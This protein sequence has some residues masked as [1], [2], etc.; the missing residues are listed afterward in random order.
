MNDVQFQFEYYRYDDQVTSLTIIS[1]V[2]YMH[3]I[4]KIFRRNDMHTIKVVCPHC[5]HITHVTNE[6]TKHDI[7]CEACGKLITDTTP[8]NCDVES[9]K[10]HLEENDIPILV[11]FYSPACASCMAMAPDY[12][13][14]ASSF[15]L[16]VRFLKIDTIDYP[17][18]ALQY[19]VNQL[20]TIIAF[21]N[22]L[23]VNRFSSQLSKEQLRM[24]AESL[25]QVTL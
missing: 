6:V 22:G 2:R 17:H 9:F 11:D 10:L 13:D 5:S 3:I 15:S 23:E 12:E 25:I 8:I 21:K 4:S 18:I 16:E 7:P 19:G 20:P 1:I 14:A 24:W